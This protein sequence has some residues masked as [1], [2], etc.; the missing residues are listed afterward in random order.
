M[1]PA[2]ALGVSL[3]VA[4]TAWR[5]RALTVSGALV[6]AAIGCAV[7]WSTG[8]AG[9]AVLGVFFLPSTLIGRW[10]ARRPGAGDARGEQ[11]DAVVAANGAA[12]ALG[13]CWPSG[14]G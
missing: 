5:A 13:R 3:A 2:L 9:G 6:A 11:R 8:W 14:R 1:P 12:A 7:L 10:G 4:L